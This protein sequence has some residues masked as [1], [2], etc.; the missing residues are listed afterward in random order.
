MMTKKAVCFMVLCVAF[1]GLSLQAGTLVLGNPPVALTG[2]CDPFGCPAFFGLGT[3]QQ[4]YLNSAFP[5][6]MTIDDLSFL[7]G[8]VPNNGGQP[9]GGMYTLSFSYTTDAPGDLNLTNPSD[10]IGADSA[11]FFTGT[12]PAL[13]AGPDGNLLSFSGTPFAYD[14]AAGNL[15][16]T[17]SVTGA[18]NSTPFL[19]L[20][21]AQ[22]GP[23][24]TCPAGSSVVTSN[25][26][27]GVANGGNNIGG[28]VSIFDYT[29]TTGISPTPEPASLLLVLAGI[30]LIA[31][32][33]R[34]RHSR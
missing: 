7:Q 32:Q 2:N 16:L 19:Y 5:S 18:K 4:V 28:L 1:T 22:C 21:Q 10:N 29:T 3:Y 11:T 12:L 9:A 27:F 17:V 34:R 23:L 30:G 14:P 8:Q 13:S 26:Y 15:L 24:T 6:A 31:F 20:D 25:A 33:G